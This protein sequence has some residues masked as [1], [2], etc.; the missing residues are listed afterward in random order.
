M[1]SD[2]FLGFKSVWRWGWQCNST[3]N[4]NKNI[5]L[6]FR[7]MFC[8]WLCIYYTCY[9]M[10]R[11][12]HGSANPS[13]RSQKPHHRH[14]P[15]SVLRNVLRHSVDVCVCVHRYVHEADLRSSIHVGNNKYLH[16]YCTRSPQS[17]VL[18][19]YPG[20]WDAGRRSAP[21][22]AQ[23]ISATITVIIMRIFTIDYIGVVHI[24]TVY[25]HSVWKTN[26]MQLLIQIYGRRPTSSSIS[27]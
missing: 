26:R 24:C 27:R 23:T 12:I 11:I 9:Y 16:G 13:E 4:N 17:A 1:S 20:A 19:S 7:N 22:T 5:I 14:I 3:T 8:D 2:I 21:R 25:M 18:A 10:L 6:Y 15:S